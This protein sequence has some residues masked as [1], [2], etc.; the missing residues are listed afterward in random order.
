MKNKTTRIGAF[1]RKFEHQND[2]LYIDMIAKKKFFIVNNIIIIVFSFEMN[3]LQQ[4]YT[5]SSLQL[6]HKFSA[7]VFC[8]KLLKV[9]K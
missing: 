2:K 3:I 1:A 6:P 7:F 4:L 5:E 9:H 8:C